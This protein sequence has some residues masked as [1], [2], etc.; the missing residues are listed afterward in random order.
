MA[1]RDDGVE[2]AIEALEDEARNF[3]FRFIQDAK[4]RAEYLSSIRQ[5]AEQIRESVRA[6]ELTPAEA[7]AHANE[8]RNRIL[9]LARMKSSD[10]GRAAAERIKIHGLRLED[11]LEKYAQKKFGKP[12]EILKPQEREVVYFEIVEAAGHARP[13]VTVRSIRLA[14]LGRGLLVVSAGIAIYSIATSA[15][16]VEAAVHEGVD[17]GGGVAGGAAGGA[18]AGLAFGPGAVVAVPIGVFVGGLA[19]ALGADFLYEWIRH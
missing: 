18:L 7:A 2:R 12:F 1:D 3:A 19:G 8:M 6:G 4:V 15:N 5:H 16:K 14:R 11:L 13:S 9:D 10:M 17:F